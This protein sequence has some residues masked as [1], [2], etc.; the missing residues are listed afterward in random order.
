MASSKKNN[1][2]CVARNKT[3]A[4][5]IS[6]K[7]RFKCVSTNVDSKKC[8]INPWAA[9]SDPCVLTENALKIRCLV[10]LLMDLC[11]IFSN[12]FSLKHFFELISAAL[13]YSQPHNFISCISTFLW[14]V[15]V[16]FIFPFIRFFITYSHHLRLPKS[17][18]NHHQNRL[19]S[20]WLYVW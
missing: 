5:E 16:T 18:R 15:F 20:I 10:M 7:A 12:Q 17:K 4:A 1:N 8:Y 14:P 11:N 2:N 6:S 9:L 3:N 19:H 13:V